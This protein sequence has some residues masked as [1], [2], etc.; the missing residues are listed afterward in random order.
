MNGNGR[1]LIRTQPLWLAWYPRRG[2]RCQVGFDDAVGGW[3]F[4]AA[5]GPLFFATGPG[6]PLP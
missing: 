1:V 5:L 2:R 4:S 6:R 3:H